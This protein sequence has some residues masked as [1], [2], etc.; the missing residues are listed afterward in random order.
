MNADLL[1]VLDDRRRGTIWTGTGADID[2]VAVAG[3]HIIA[4]GAEARERR[5]SRTEVVEV[6]G[7]TL[8]PAFR[9]G[10]IHPLNGGAETL[11]CDLVDSADVDEVLG[12]LASFA[13]ERPDEPWILG[14]GYPPEILPGG[15][16]RAAVLDAVVGDRPVALWSSDHHMV[17]C[18]SAALRT[19]DITAATADP[20]RGT[21]VR[22]GDG[23]PVGTLLEE[24]AHLL[25][26]HLPPRGVE[27]LA[28]GLEVGLER[29]TSAGLVWG[30]DA[31]IT[32]S[33]LPAFA[34][35]A[36]AGALTV[37]L[38]LAPK[39]EVDSWR[40]QVA[41]FQDA[42]ADVDA[43][44]GRR[45][46]E[47]VPGGRLGLSTVKLFVDGV[48]EGGTGAL[49]EPY[50]ALDHDPDSGGGHGIANWEPG[51]LARAC[52]AFDAAGFQL[53]LHAI[54]DR[55]VRD[56]LDAFEHVAATN[57]ADDR[58]PVVAHTHLVHPD[59]RDRLRALGA[60][61]NFEPLWAQ[62]NEVM[63][64][65]TAPRLGPERSRW[66][67]P[68]GSL[69][70]SGTHVSFGS[71]WPVSSHVPLRGIQIAV[72][73][74]VPGDAAAGVLHPDERISRAQALAAYTSGV[75][76]QAGEEAVA[77][78]I[79]VGQRADLVVT[80]ADVTRVPAE[81]LGQVPVRRT[82]RAGTTVHRAGD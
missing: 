63:V 37:D 19:A 38:D 70:R 68:I 5:G 64:D 44:A 54:G 62:P 18:N 3:G 40:D 6:G 75:A 31:W 45:A 42:R 15:V 26:G 60:V 67:Y 56:A 82:W 7:G 16:G 58:R 73:R 13:A 65:L 57:G 29:M 49:L 71:D 30:Q 2:A 46:A 36:E 48:I 78:A 53:H 47:G 61:A 1:V 8:L 17:W 10:H 35:V 55:A 59:D 69:L 81:L 11:D 25:D 24:A 22:D 66:Q 12:R 9:D 74:Q 72:T 32:L 39:V 76:Y 34:R 21:V 23:V 28:R 52:A 27:K 43:A 33:M 77:G 51:E 79:A 50:C 80:E 14:W 20:P 4:L 41:A